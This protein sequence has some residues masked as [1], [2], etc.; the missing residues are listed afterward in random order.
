M[1][2]IGLSGTNPDYSTDSTSK[3]IPN[4]F[5]S[6]LQTKFYDATVLTEISN[7]DFSGEI[8]AQGDRV[9]IRVLPDV[10]IVDYTK[11]G[12]LPLQR[13]SASSIE[14]QID[15]AKAFNFAIDDIDIHQMDLDWMSQLSADA[16]EQLKINT[17]TVVFGQIFSDVNASNSG[18]TAG[19][20]TSSVD[21]GVSGTL[22]SVTKT[23]VLDKIVECGQVLDEQNV[24]GTDRWMVIPPQMAAIIKKSDLKDASL[25]GDSVTPMRNG[26]IGQLD[27]FTLYTSNL[28]TQAESGFHIPFGHKSA[29]AFASQINKVE[30]YNHPDTFE[31][32]MKG[33]LVYGFKVVTPKAMGDLFTT[34]S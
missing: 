4:L 19:V 1:S 28:L 9:T 17:D 33:L 8:S 24:P 30:A 7:T 34:I 16:S 11:G 25:T 3:Y 27:R 12:T 32:A 5:A 23:N 13:A 26:L 18:S 20:D 22:A 10:N 15:R 21:L 29:L 14:L 31:K 6:K 2:L